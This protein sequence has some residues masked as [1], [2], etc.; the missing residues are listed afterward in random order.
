MNKLL[1]IREQLNLTQQE[2]SEKTG[3]SVRTIQ[4]IESGTVPKGYT[5]KA[6]CNALEIN[7]VE[8]LENKRIEE[9]DN[10]QHQWAKIINLS[11]LLFTFIPPLNI[12]IPVFILFF[13]KQNNE[14]T[15]KII[16]IQILWTI[17]AVLLF[18]VILI[19]TDW[20]GIQTQF[21]FLIPIVWILVNII[22]ILR[23]AVALNKDK[24]PRIYPNISIL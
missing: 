22:I 5:L 11:S 12:L 23:N 19:L 20:L 6:L 9:D 15:R 13:K 21:K 7:E 3:V 24:N 4:R 2:L 8:L 14:L 16:S 17:I 1:A 10:N 18:I